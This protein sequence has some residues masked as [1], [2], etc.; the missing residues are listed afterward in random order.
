MCI[1]WLNKV[2]VGVNG[3]FL[4][5]IFKS[6]KSSCKSVTFYGKNT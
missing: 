6:K 3:T 1:L 5:P 4:G 2:G